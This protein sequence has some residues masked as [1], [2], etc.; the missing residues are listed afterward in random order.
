MRTANI[1]L[2]ALRDA[3]KAVCEHC[4]EDAG[5]ML[6]PFHDRNFREQHGHLIGDVTFLC[7]ATPIW[8]IVVE[9]FGVEKVG[10]PCR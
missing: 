8:K 3:A 6:P 10:F 2:R 1:R 7:K 9:E 4:R 5:Q